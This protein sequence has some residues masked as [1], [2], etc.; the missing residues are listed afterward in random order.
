MGGQN[1]SAMGAQGKGV[2]GNHDATA[3]GGAKMADGAK[4][5]AGMIADGISQSLRFLLILER[6]MVKSYFPLL[7]TWNCVS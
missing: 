6:L 5:I 2:A 1:A 3:M 7:T 4:D